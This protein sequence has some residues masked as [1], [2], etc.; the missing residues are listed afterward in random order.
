MAFD[1]LPLHRPPDPPSPRRGREAS[2]STAR[3]LIVGAGLVV[4]GSMLALW[5][6]S[7]AQPP[8]VSPAPATMSDPKQAERRPKRELLELPPLEGSDE[9]L[10]ALVAQLSHDS[11]LA[12]LLGT[13]DLARN[14]TLAVV[15][16]GD[17]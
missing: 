11:L 12:R 2:S 1:D 17:G 3:W 8:T 10:R 13:R 4:A 5:W 9:M 15:Q 14:M 6:L 7:R 16:I